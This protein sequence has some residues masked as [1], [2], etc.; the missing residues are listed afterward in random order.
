LVTSFLVRE[1]S[2]QKN[3]S[4][5]FF[6]MRDIFSP[7]PLPLFRAPQRR[8]HTRKSATVSERIALRAPRA[9][10]EISASAT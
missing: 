5:R 7:R 3:T 2:N 6:V 9:M 1:F 8:A 4:Q 10:R